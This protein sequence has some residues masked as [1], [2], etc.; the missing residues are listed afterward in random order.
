MHK[1]NVNVFVNGMQYTIQVKLCGF[2]STAYTFYLV[3][4]LWSFV[5]CSW[6]DFYAD[7]FA[8]PVVIY[9]NWDFTFFLSAL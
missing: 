6:S 1:L 4:E 3:I 5:L 8:L 9:L 7:E 2:G